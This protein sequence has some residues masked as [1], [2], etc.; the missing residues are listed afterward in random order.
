MFAAVDVRAESHA[1]FA[2]FAQP[3]QAHDLKS[4]GI[5]QNRLIP[6]HKLMQ[7][8][9]FLHQIG[10]RPQHQ[11]ISIAEQN[12]RPGSRHRFRHHRLNRAAGAD[13]HKSRRIDNSVFGIKFTQAAFA[14]FFDYFVF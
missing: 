9:H 14:A 1:V 8:A 4:A 13:R 5:R 11:V 3:G 12:F 2:E 6:V 7:A 10:A